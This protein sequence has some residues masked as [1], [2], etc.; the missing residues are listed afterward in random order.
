MQRILQAILA[1]KT[2]S[3]EAQKKLLASTDEDWCN[4]TKRYVKTK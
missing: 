3:G 4:A 2:L 1:T